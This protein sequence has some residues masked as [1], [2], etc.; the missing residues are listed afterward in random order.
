MFDEVLDS[1]TKIKKIRKILRATQEQIA[2]K[3]I[4]R[5]LLSQIENGKVKLTEPTANVIAKNI[6]IICKEKNINL[7][8]VITTEYL[9]EDKEEQIN[10]IVNKCLKD[11]KLIS[12]TKRYDEFK[13]KLNEIEKKLEKISDSKKEKIYEVAANFF[14]ESYEY[15]ESEFYILKCYNIAAKNEDDEKMIECLSMR[16]NVYSKMGQYEKVLNLERLAE[17]I[18]KN[19]DIG[20]LSV[21]KNIY[22]NTAIAL[23]NLGEYTKCIE[24]LKKIMISFKLPINKLL[25]VKIIMANCHSELKEYNKAKCIYLNILDTS[26]ETDYIL[27]IALIYANMAELFLKTGEIDNAE[28]YIEKAISIKNIKNDNKTAEIYYD[29][30]LVYTSKRNNMEK[31]TQ[32]F[33]DT[34]HKINIVKNKRMKVKIIN[35]MCKY[36]IN[37]RREDILLNILDIIKNCVNNENLVHE[38]FVRIFYR[39][40]N[41]LKEID[42]KKANDVLATGLYI[43]ELLEK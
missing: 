26:I 28:M 13:I 2:G 23:K 1:G 40:Y 29:A 42:S 43:D 11:L 30:F 25:D 24:M 6:E 34:I 22:F 5:V 35:N 8:K 32:I 39:S 31:V 19:N 38:T 7:R 17:V 41:F 9:L 33:F 12:I 37:E 20:K 14:Y 36:C 21:I 15:E 3:E 18:L 16:I 10:K 4:T 27:M